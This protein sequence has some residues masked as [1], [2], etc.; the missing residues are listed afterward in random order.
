MQGFHLRQSSPLSQSGIDILRADGRECDALDTILLRQ[1]QTIPIA[2]CQKI[3]LA[4]FSAA[5][6]G[7]G[8]MND[9]FC[10][11]FVALRDFASPVRQP[12]SVS[13]S[14]KAP[15]PPPD[16]WHHLPPPPS[17]DVLAALTIA[18]VFAFTISPFYNRQ[19][20]HFAIPFVRFPCPIILSSF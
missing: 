15:A 13:H 12:C 2:I 7:T 17:R 5:P 20:F 8:R 19:T 3:L 14:A 4:P 1:C 10:L 16:E 11:Q 9:I 6:N 18:S